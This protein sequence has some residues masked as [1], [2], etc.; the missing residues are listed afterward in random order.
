MV[1]GQ[2]RGR[3][4]TDP[5]V[6]AAMGSVPR[7]EFVAPGDESFAYDDRAMPIGY[8]QTISQ[9]YMVGLMCQ[10]LEVRPEDRVLEVG[11]GSGYQAAVLGQL[12]AEVY[13]IEIVPELARR[14][15]LTIRRLG[16]G[17]VHVIEQDGTLGYPPSGPYQRI[18]IAAAAPA[19]PEPLVE[20]L[21]EGG[22]LVA[23]VGDLRVQTCIVATRNG[24][25]LQVEHSIGCVFVPL[26]GEH[27]W[28]GGSGE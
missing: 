16:Y 4:I 13:S 9:P 1:Q 18:I 12:A 23:P 27:G 22:R 25:E 19:V 10:L 15:D 14:A 3:G 6:L 17:N 28:H 11:G 5:R 24:D 8:G 26:R 2:L 20:Q 21:V 7:H